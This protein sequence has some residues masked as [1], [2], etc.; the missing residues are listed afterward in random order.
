M[1]KQGAQAENHINSNIGNPLKK[2]EKELGNNSGWKVRQAM[3]DQEKLWRMGNE[4]S[5][6]E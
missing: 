6:W 1:N 3:I 5:F 4:K 2:Y